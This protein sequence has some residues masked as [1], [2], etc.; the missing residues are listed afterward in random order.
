MC[1]SA[2][3]T[4]NFA[5]A[6]I[7]IFIL[8]IPCA[9]LCTWTHNDIIRHIDIN[10]KSIAVTWAR[11]WERERINKRRA[12]SNCAVQTYTRLTD[13]VLE[14]MIEWEKRERMRPVKRNR[15]ITQT[16]ITIIIKKNS[17]FIAIFRTTIASSSASLCVHCV[18]CHTVRRCECVCVHVRNPIVN[19][20]IK[21]NVTVRPKIREKRWINERRR[22]QVSER[23][24]PNSI[25]SLCVCKFNF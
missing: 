7:F 24:W 25:L 14:W 10:V 18:Q 19:F 15:A 12:H 16:I 2:H 17:I 21:A 9:I 6:A 3:C 23:G 4:L 5:S 13:W 20:I 8:T 22:E 1:V 11:K